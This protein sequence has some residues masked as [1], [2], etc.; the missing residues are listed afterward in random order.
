V[1]VLSASEP[2]PR[3]EE[4]GT[5]KRPA[6]READGNPAAQKRARRMFGSLMGTLAKAR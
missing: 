6:P 2:A 5:A 3:R 1:Q 4:F